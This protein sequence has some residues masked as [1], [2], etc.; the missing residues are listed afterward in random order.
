MLFELILVLEP[1]DPGD[2]CEDD[3]EP[4]ISYKH[5]AY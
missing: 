3:T 4:P 2:F 1:R 5:L